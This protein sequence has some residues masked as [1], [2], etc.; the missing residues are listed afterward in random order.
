ML[1]T[2]HGMM[3]DAGTVRTSVEMDNEGLNTMKQARLRAMNHTNSSSTNKF[4]GKTLAKRLNASPDPV[5]GACV[6]DADE[7]FQLY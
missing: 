6:F 7:N 4:N 2:R 3:N 5:I 1:Q